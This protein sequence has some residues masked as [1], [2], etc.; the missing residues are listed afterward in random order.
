MG[1][2]GLGTGR[3]SVEMGTAGMGMGTA[4]MARGKGMDLASTDLAGMGPHM[5]MYWS[6]QPPPRYFRRYL[7]P[8]RMHQEPVRMHRHL[9]PLSPPS[10]RSR[11]ATSD[12]LWQSARPLA[13]S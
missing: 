5:D 2:S 13:A 12:E 3:V 8:V 6:S 11:G 7:E 4:G 9:Q 10:R 1:M